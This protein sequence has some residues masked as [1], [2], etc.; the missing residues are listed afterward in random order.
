MYW[1]TFDLPAFHHKVSQDP[2]K[3]NYLRLS[4]ALLYCIILFHTLLLL[5]SSSLFFFLAVSMSGLKWTGHVQSIHQTEAFFAQVKCFQTSQVMDSFHDRHYRTFLHFFIFDG[6]YSTMRLIYKMIQGDCC[7][8]CDQFNP[9]PSNNVVPRCAKSHLSNLQGYRLCVYVW[10]AHPQSVSDWTDWSPPH[11]LSGPDTQ[12][13]TGHQNRQGSS[14]W[15]AIGQRMSADCTPGRWRRWT[16]SM[17]VGA[18]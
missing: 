3:P 2:P 8:H 15:V 13:H 18:G 9:L 4:L 16:W 10:V 12:S 6:R 11:I 17:E 7:D 5:I 1:S 14:S